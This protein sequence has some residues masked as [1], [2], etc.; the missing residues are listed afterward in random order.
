MDFLQ[1]AGANVTGFKSHT[2]C[3]TDDGKKTI[4]CVLF[5]ILHRFGYSVFTYGVAKHITYSFLDYVLIK[6]LA[7]V[8]VSYLM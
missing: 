7:D 1:A 2:T 5:T 3:V 8:I 6:M 4:D